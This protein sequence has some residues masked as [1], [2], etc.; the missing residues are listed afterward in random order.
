VGRVRHSRGSTSADPCAASRD[1]DES[2]ELGIP[3]GFLASIDERSQYRESGEMHDISLRVEDVT[4]RA[5][6]AHMDSMYAALSGGAATVGY[7]GAGVW[8]VGSWG[9]CAGLASCWWSVGTTRE[10]LHA[11]LAGRTET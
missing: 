4:G 1:F 8:D 9:R 6:E 10:Q 5:V 7:E 11:G 3:I 2:R